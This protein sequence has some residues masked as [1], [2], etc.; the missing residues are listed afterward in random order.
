MR[1]VLAFAAALCIN[2]AILHAESV[3]YQVNG[4]AWSDFGRIMKTSDSLTPGGRPNIMLDL[5][6]NSLVSMGGQFTIQADL[7]DHWEAA[8][9][10]GTHKVSHSMGHGQ[11]AFL[12]IS[13]FHHYLTESRLAWYAGEKEAPSFSV[14]VGS[15]PY[16]YNGDVQNLGLYLFRGPVYPGILMGGFQDFA[17]DST[18]STQLGAKIHHAMGNFS[19]DIILNSER[20]IP[21]TFDW[22][23]GYVAKYR[24][25]NALEIG[26]GANFYRLFAYNEELQTPGKISEADLRG[27]SR[28]RYIETDPAKPGDT[29]FFTHQGIKAMGM[30]S[31]DLKPMLGIESMGKN[32]LKIYSEG[33]VLGLKNYGKTYGDISKRIPIMFGVNLPTWGLLDRLAIEVEHYGSPYR[34]DL[35]RLGN[36]NMVADWTQQ[37]HPIP[38]PKPVDNSDYGIDTAG[39]WVNSLGET[40]NLRGTALDKENVTSDDLKWSLNVEKIFSGHIHLLAQAANDHYRPRPTATNL[41]TAS[42]GTAEAFNENSNWYFMLRMGY[43]F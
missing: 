32:D 2:A 12:S 3:T 13:M 8:F 43:F 6:G 18:K 40:V 34:N 14:T 24:A 4:G 26:A 28:A 25:F 15:F 1:K 42:G 7:A 35:S 33:A 36:N 11:K 29:V 9:G 19:H 10:F 22:S 5:S 16:K 20:D 23:L 39:N 27:V 37:E 17:V 21:P 38:S 30:F 31:L 41:I